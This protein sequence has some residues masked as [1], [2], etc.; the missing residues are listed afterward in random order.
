MTVDPSF[1]VEFDLATR[2]MRFLDWQNFAVDEVPHKIYWVHCDLE[3]KGALAFMIEK[4]AITADVATDIHRTDKA[5]QILEREDSLTLQ[6]QCLFRQANPK[7]KLATNDLVIH[8]TSRYCL[9]V[10]RGRVPIL[11]G[12]MKD[13]PNAIQYAR[14]PCFILFLIQDN[15]ITY[16]SEILY[17]YEILAEDLDARANQNVYKHIINVKRRVLN[18]KRHTLIVLNTLLYTSGRDIKV[19]SKQCKISLA[20]L[21]NNTQTVV[22]EADSIRDLL[23]ST[24]DQIDNALMRAVNDTMR[25]LTAIAAIF[26]PPSLI[27]AIYGMNFHIPE[28]SWKYG[29]AYALVLILSSMIAIICYFKKKKW[30]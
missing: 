5:S 25:V 11:E 13:L 3:E 27:A 23:N 4:L 22:N 15:L 7:D 14:T 10:T 2:G 12:L 6:M 20:T 19:I 28:L 17:D 16:Y 26:M 30:Y 9:T 21:L 1:I 8:L 29:Y 24:L 18:V